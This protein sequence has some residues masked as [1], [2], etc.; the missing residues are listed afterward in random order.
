[1]YLVVSILLKF[2]VVLLLLTLITLRL[3]GRFLH[4]YTDAQMNV[5]RKSLDFS[6]LPLPPPPNLYSLG[7]GPEFLKGQRRLPEIFCEH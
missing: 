2:S 1:M 6:S 5:L 3:L 4:S 7:K